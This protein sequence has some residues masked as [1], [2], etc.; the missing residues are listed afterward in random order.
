MDADPPACALVA[1]DQRVRGSPGSS[2]WEG[3]AVDRAL[4]VPT[5]S[6]AVPR[7]TPIRFELEGPRP[8]EVFLSAFRLQDLPHPARAVWEGPLD[9]DA[10]TWTADLEAGS[11]VLSLFRAWQGRGDASQQFGL[12]VLAE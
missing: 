6:V 2:V 8:T 4:E 10:P 5:E 11:Y 1:D 9:P 12:E 3:I 7:G